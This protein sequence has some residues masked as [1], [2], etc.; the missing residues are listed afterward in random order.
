MKE[1][2]ARLA[3]LALAAAAASSFA[4]A[5]VVDA[6]ENGFTV[7]ET[8]LVSAPPA[9]AWAALVDVGKW[10][11]SEHSFSG[12][13]ANL[14]LDPKPQGCWCEKLPGGGGVRHMTVIY[15]SAPKLLRFEGGLGPL[16]AIGA[17]G[18]MSWKLDPAEKGTTFELR[19]TVGGYHP[20]GFAQ[21]APIV[22][23]VLKAQVERYKRFVETGKP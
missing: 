4:S 19:Y 22:D 14:S 20:G 5:E 10:W 21:L 1:S 7:R 18:S 13:A 8:V 23:G 11:S 6:A 12:D 16:Q 2:L 15:A 17:G 9:K 3:A